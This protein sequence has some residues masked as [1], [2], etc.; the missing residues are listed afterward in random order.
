MSM[1][2][3]HQ[4]AHF[5]FGA[6]TSDAFL[7]NSSSSENRSP[8]NQSCGS[9]LSINVWSCCYFLSHSFPLLSTHSPSLLSLGGL[10]LSSRGTTCATSS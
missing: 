10:I 9:D 5:I 6:L 7:A 1:L 2:M 3:C 8:K 4:A